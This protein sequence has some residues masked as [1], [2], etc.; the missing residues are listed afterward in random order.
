[1]QLHGRE[2]AEVVREVKA[3]FEGEVWTA[4]D[5]AHDLGGDRP[6][7]D[8]GAGGTGHPFDWSSLKGQPRLA[9]AF[10]AGG[11]GPHNARAAQATGVYGIDAGSQLE[12]EPGRKDP[13][14][15]R[16]LFDVLRPIDRS[17]A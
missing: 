13:G 10:L 6:L 17:A 15:V 12:R 3:R 2:D 4:S 7:F 9:S 8:N 14:K 11:I 1:M 5:G 16:A